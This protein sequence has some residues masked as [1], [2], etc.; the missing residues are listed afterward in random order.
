MT[1]ITLVRHAAVEPAWKRRC[2]G[3]RCDPPLSADGVTEAVRLARE[4]ATPGLV[5]CSPARRAR[6]TAR[7]V[8]A[9][10]IVDARWAERDFGEWEGRTWDDC[11][12]HVPACATRDAASYARYTPPGAEPFARVTA[13][14]VNALAGLSTDMTSTVVTHAGPM[15][16]TL[17]LAGMALEEAFAAAIGPCAGI[18]FT[19]ANG[20][21]RLR[22]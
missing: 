6:E 11:W 16:A 18:T 13:R 20:Q 3:S 14:I 19:R 9:D 7:R 22:R 5:I 10:F 2:Y 12:A 17:V 15:R 21:L 1:E 4:L 8:T